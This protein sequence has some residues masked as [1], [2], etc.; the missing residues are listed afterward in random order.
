MNGISEKCK[1]ELKH[2]FGEF[3]VTI[4]NEYWRKTEGYKNQDLT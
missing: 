2:R 1:T 4:S 3:I